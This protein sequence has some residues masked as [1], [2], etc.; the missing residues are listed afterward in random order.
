MRPGAYVRCD[1]Y[2]KLCHDSSAKERSAKTL[3]LLYVM[4]T[5][6]RS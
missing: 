6:S 4:Y 5:A 3:F 2:I 1:L